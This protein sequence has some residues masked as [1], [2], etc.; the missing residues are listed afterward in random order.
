MMRIAITGGTGFAG[1]HLAALLD[2][3]GHEVVIVSRPTGHPIGRGG[4]ARKPLS[5]LGRHVRHLLE[6]RNATIK[7]DAERVWSVALVELLP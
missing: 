2:A 4:A 1:R 5:D 7:E 3:N 6:S